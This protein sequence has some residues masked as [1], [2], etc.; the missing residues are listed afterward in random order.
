MIAEDA[1]NPWAEGDWLGDEQMRMSVTMAPSHPYK[2][3]SVSPDWLS[4]CGFPPSEIVGHTL[5]VVQREGTERPRVEALCAAAAKG[6]PPNPAAP[7]Q[8]TTTASTTT[9]STDLDG[10]GIA[11]VT[12]QTTTNR[13]PRRSTPR[14]GRSY[15]DRRLNRDSLPP[16]K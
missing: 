15:S 11:D 5:K 16:Y 10:D 4:F 14:T 3:T 9:T 8:T 2:V 6:G 13:P 7:A 12:V 1:P